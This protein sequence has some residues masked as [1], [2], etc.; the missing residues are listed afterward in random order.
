VQTI[1]PLEAVRR[2]ICSAL[3]RSGVRVSRLPLSKEL[4]ADA[5][6]DPSLAGFLNPSRGFQIDSGLRQLAKK[7]VRL[8]LLLKR[9]IQERRSIVHAELHG[10]RLQ[11]TVA[12]NFIVLNGLTAGEETSVEGFAS[13]GLHICGHA[14][15]V[16]GVD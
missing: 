11:R 8:L 7:G 14:A 12:R 4:R 9:L 15:L 2:P 16:L 13:S 10:P 5:A 3:G 1:R 6:A